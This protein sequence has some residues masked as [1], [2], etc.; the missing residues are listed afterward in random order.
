MTWHNAHPG[1]E[2]PH[3]KPFR[4]CLRCKYVVV[5]F[6]DQWWHLSRKSQA[7]TLGAGKPGVP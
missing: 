2:H 5:Y 7:S 3:G 6:L 1:S 4:Y